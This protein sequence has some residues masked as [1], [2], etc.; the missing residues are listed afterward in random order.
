M[1]R[2]S[3]RIRTVTTLNAENWPY[4]SFAKHESS[5][6]D[7]LRKIFTPAILAEHIARLPPESRARLERQFGK[8]PT[9]TTTTQLP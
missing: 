3:H 6:S 8:L 5:Y 4:A 2:K 7:A 9:V 1:K